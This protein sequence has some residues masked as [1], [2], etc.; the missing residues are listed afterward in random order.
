VYPTAGKWS[1]PKAYSATDRTEVQ[2]G[3]QWPLVALRKPATAPALLPGRQDKAVAASTAVARAS[4]L[5]NRFQKLDQGPASMPA[6]PPP[7]QRQARSCEAIAAQA[8][9]RAET[10]L[11]Q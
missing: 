5:H 7:K 4:H 10:G 1:L 6:A 2:A 9:C 8:R 11:R 3:A